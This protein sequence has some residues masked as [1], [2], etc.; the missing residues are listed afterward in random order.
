MCFILCTSHLKERERSCLRVY[1]IQGTLCCGSADTWITR[2]CSIAA[3]RRGYC[4][5]HWLE[6]EIYKEP[7][8]AKIYLIMAMCSLAK[9]CT[10]NMHHK[11]CCGGSRKA[12][13]LSQIIIES[14]QKRRLDYVA[15]FS[16]LTE[17]LCVTS[18]AFRSLLLGNDRSG[19]PRDDKSIPTGCFSSSTWCPK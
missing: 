15:T 9:F 10:Q 17:W 3:E 13:R 2:H 1:V 11:A 12:S 18:A 6:K 14:Q 5:F 19:S 16:T 7:C 4:V 8:T